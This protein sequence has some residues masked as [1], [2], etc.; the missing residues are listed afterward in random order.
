ME[1]PIER[2]IAAHE[3]YL[4]LDRRRADCR[5]PQEREILHIEILQAYVDVQ[6]HAK[7]ITGVQPAEGME[8]ACAK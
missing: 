4:A 3:H 8:F 7:I 5:S 1:S 2:F 6:H